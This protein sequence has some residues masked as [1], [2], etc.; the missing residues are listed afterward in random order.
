[1]YNILTLPLFITPYQQISDFADPEYEFVLVWCIEFACTLWYPY[2]HY[3]CYCTPGILLNRL[4]WILS[5]ALSES[6]GWFTNQRPSACISKG[7][8]WDLKAWLHPRQITQVIGFP[9]NLWTT[10]FMVN[11][12]KTSL[13]NPS[14]AIRYLHF[15]VVGQRGLFGETSSRFKVVDFT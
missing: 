12:Q 1:M 6:L 2:T 7:K 15:Q 14:V 13:R 8:P 3:M 5:K 4:K 10:Q 11:G 9:R